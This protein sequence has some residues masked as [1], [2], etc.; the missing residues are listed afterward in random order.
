MPL[1]G[2]CQFTSCPILIYLPLPLSRIGGGFFRCT[3]FCKL[4]LLP[5]SFRL[6]TVFNLNLVSPKLRS[7]TLPLNIS[8][9]SLLFGFLQ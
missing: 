2:L 5:N 1:R 9:L 7:L 6:I 8:A 4:L 3:F